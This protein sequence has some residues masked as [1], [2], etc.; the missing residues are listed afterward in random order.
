M[1][2]PNRGNWKPG[3]E[4]YNR[5]ECSASKAPENTGCWGAAGTEYHWQIF[6]QNKIQD[7]IDE[8]LAFSC[9][10]PMNYTDNSKLK[11]C[12]ASSFLLS[13]SIKS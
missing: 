1:V 7:E 6:E 10:L 13:M 9:Q 3:D 4:C 8:Q 12:C 11:Y 5:V 2:D